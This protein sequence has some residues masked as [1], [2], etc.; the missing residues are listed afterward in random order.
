M[1]NKHWDVNSTNEVVTKE[2]SNLEHENECNS[3]DVLE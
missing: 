2:E 1:H 3:G